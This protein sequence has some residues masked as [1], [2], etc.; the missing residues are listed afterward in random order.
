MWLGLSRGIVCLWLACSLGASARAIRASAACWGRGA[1]EL[2]LDLAI[3]CGW[4]C[5]AVAELLGWLWAAGKLVGIGARESVI[6]R[7]L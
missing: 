6:E 1:E 4:A 2:A 7:R 3:G 5:Q